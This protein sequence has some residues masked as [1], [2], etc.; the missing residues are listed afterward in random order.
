MAPVWVRLKPDVSRPQE[1]LTELW[2]VNKGC[3][4]ALYPQCLGV[5][6]VH[7]CSGVCE[8]LRCLSEVVNASRRN[9]WWSPRLMD[10]WGFHFSTHPRSSGQIGQILNTPAQQ[11][12]AHQPLLV[13]CARS[14]FAQKIKITRNY[15][16]PPAPTSAPSVSALTDLHPAIKDVV[17]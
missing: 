12:L 15:L 13:S 3:F 17:V 8:S 16:L 10:H 6:C 1:A 11:K 9:I 14:L 2:S 7:W 5:W 4:P